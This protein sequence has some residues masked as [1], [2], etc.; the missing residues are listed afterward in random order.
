[1]PI[2]YLLHVRIFYLWWLKQ[3]FSFYKVLK[4]KINTLDVRRTSHNF[5]TRLL[6]EIESYYTIAKPKYETAVIYAGL[7]T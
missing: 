5:A 1:V 3:N 2:N 6:S 7:S 4:V